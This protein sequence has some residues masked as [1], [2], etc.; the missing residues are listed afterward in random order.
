MFSRDDAGL[1]RHWGPRADIPGAAAE[2]RAAAAGVLALLSVLRLD[3]PQPAAAAVD[4][5][6]TSLTDQPVSVFT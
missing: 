5:A 1:P 4:A 6:I 2:A 3:L